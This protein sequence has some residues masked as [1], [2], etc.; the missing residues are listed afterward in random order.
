MK[1]E[2]IL[3]VNPDEKQ[4]A[5]EFAN[6]AIGHGLDATL[7]FHKDKT[8]VQVPADQFG[9]GRDFTNGYFAD[10]RGGIKK[11]EL[12]LR[13]CS[14]STKAH[15]EN[16]DGHARIITFNPAVN[17]VV[18]MIE[19]TIFTGKVITASA[20]LSLAELVE[21]LEAKIKAGNGETA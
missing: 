19:I 6:A 1:R 14:I 20:E 18:P 9:A 4:A 16:S 21:I 13:P 11:G 12:T 10:K 7:E 3:A 2:T 17:S 15:Y 5:M 8:I